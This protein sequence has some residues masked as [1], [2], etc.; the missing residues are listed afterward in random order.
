MRTPATILFAAA[1][2]TVTA[3]A[4][5]PSTPTTL[6]S[7]WLTEVM[8]LDVPA[9]AAAYERVATG[10]GPRNLE[11]W[12]AVARLAEL[13]RAGAIPTMPASTQDAPTPLRPTFQALQPLPGIDELLARARRAPTEGLQIL[14][15]EATKTPPLRPAVPAVEQWVMSQ[16]G[17]SLRDRMRQRLQSFAARSR[18]TDARRFTERLYAYDVVR[19][20]LQGRTTQANALRTL[21]FA[22]WHAPA[23]PGDPLPHLERLRQNLALWLDEPDLGTQQQTVLRDL[24]E[25]IEKQAATDPAAALALVL[26]LP[27][28]AERL[29]EAKPASSNAPTRR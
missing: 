12:I 14:V 22:D 17:P 8:D 11:R 26:R 1:V 7:A 18:T 27:L 3:R 5:P 10:T 20:E 13:H 25:A 15:P 29:L 2:V 16:I 19:A 9:A 24:G 4:Q 6:H 23:A 21:Y 28:F